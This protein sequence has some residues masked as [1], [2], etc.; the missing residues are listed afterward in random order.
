MSAHDTAMKEKN[1]RTENSMPTHSTSGSELVDMFFSM[2]AA[3][4]R[5]KEYIRGMFEKAYNQMPLETLKAAFYCRDIRGGQGERR[6]FRIF[7]RYL[8]EK[9]PN[10]ARRNL[11][12]IPKYGR[13]DDVLHSTVG[14]PVEEDALEF[15][16]DQL[17][18][19]CEKVFGEEFSFDGVNNFIS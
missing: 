15:I 10:V 5:S 4:G 6:T 7:F 8:A 11:E 13:W 16:N 2:G 1:A 18:E 14:T 3:R 12:L 17:D 9:D 19:D